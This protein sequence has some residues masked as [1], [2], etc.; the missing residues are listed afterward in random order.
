MVGGELLEGMGR[1]KQHDIRMDRQGSPARGAVTV[2][3]SARYMAMGSVVLAPK[4]KATPGLT[5]VASTST[6]SKTCSKSLAMRVRAFIA[7]R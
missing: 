4:G 5:G 3:V 7:L 6:D 2:K 1:L